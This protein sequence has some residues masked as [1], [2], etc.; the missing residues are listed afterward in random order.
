[1]SAISAAIP[2]LFV[3]L[4][5]AMISKSLDTG[6][7]LAAASDASIISV[8]ISF[9]FTDTNSLDISH[10]ITLL[11]HQLFD[12]PT[13]NPKR[14]VASRRMDDCSNP[15]SLWL[16]SEC[17]RHVSPQAVRVECDD[18]TVPDNEHNNAQEYGYDINCHD[19]EICVDVVKFNPNLHNTPNH[20][21]PWCNLAYCVNN[22]NFVKIAQSQLDWMTKPESVTVPY[23]PVGDAKVEALLTGLNNN[24]SV[25]AKSLEMKPQVQGL[26]S[27]EMQ[28]STLSAGASSCIDCASLDISEVPA[29]TQRILVHATLPTTVTA[30]LLY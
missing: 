24:T 23:V 22:L 21:N 7:S 26:V 2:V 12:T 4:Y 16:E 11:S 10:R 29:G 13:P 15:P 28:W 25:F 30:A 20:Y 27:G 8:P 17:L 9:F 3:L 1:M 14:E 5:L 19:N 6:M 18:R